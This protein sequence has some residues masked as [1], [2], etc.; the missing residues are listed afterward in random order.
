MSLTADQWAV[1]QSW[2]GST[3]TEAEFSTR[4]DRIEGTSGNETWEDS[5]ILDAAI[6]E[7]LRYNIAS[8]ASD[9]SS[10][11]LPSGMSVSQGENIRSWKMLLDLFISE[12]GT[13]GEPDGTG[14]ATLYKRVRPELR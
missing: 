9:P 1:A 11:S 6:V 4:Y 10:F 13:D 8:T 7:S 3:H 12:G 14:G 5:Q 2:L